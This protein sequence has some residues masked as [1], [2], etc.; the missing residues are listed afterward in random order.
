MS[1]VRILSPRPLILLGIFPKRSIEKGQN[2]SPDGAPQG[3][4]LIL[5]PKVPVGFL[6]KRLKT[7]LFAFLGG[8]L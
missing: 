1:Q 6:G 2:G 7:L 3:V 5:V 4:L 8:L